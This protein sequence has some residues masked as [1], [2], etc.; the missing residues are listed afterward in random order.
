MEKVAEN[1]E[2]YLNSSQKRPPRIRSGGSGIC[3]CVPQCGSASYDKHKLNSGIGF[4]IFPEN[5]PF[6]K[7]GKILLVSIEGKGGA[8]LLKSRK[9]RAFVNFISRQKRSKFP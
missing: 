9:Q 6:S 4:F 5:V 1:E 3:C 8:I 2:T 7:F